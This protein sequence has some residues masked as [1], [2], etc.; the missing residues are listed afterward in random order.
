MA[1]TDAQKGQLADLY[2]QASDTGD[3]ASMSRIKAALQ[4]DREAQAP[5]PTEGMSTAQKFFAG[6]G[7]TLNRWNNTMRMMNAGD[8]VNPETGEVV[9]QSKLRAAV[10]ADIAEQKQRDKPLMATTAGSLGSVAPNA[11]LTL[12]GG[13][14]GAVAGGAVGGALDTGDVQGAAT[15]AA[16]GLAG[17]LA[18][19]VVGAGLK[20]GASKLTDVGKEAVAFLQQHGINLSM[21]QLTGRDIA[22]TADA[23][24]GQVKDLTT[25]ALKFMG[26]SSDRASAPVMDA[27]RR[28]LQN[29]YNDIAARTQ[30]KFSPEFGETLSHL[31]STANDLLEPGQAKI[32]NG[33]I[34]KIRNMAMSGPEGAPGMTIS[35]TA[36]KNLEESIGNVSGDGG[37][38][39][40]VDGIRSAMRDAMVQS[41]S[42]ADAALLARTNQQYSAMKLLE[43]SIGNKG[44]YADRIDPNKLASAVDT[45][46]NASASVYGRGANAELAQLGNYAG[47]IM[48]NEPAE[49]GVGAL[50][51]EI[52]RRLAVGGILGYGT[53]GRTGSI[54]EGGILGIGAALGGPALV[55]AMVSNPMVKN[56][57]VAFATKNGIRTAADVVARGARMGGQAT[58]GAVAAAGNQPQ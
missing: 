11:A 32:I 57:V 3:S 15:G 40:F 44:I 41:A 10:Q 19:K 31:E 25:A 55:R 21:G 6:A 5:N 49:K 17:G 29:A 48:G 33:Q 4:A 12:A 52:T 28:V 1:L 46:R 42:P 53:Y 14:P 27:G 9:D 43:K 36:F 38:Q 18:G 13:I 24:L 26:V 50:A 45:A 30:V 58:G 2:Q 7:A 34:A 56:A 20:A 23:A 39:P 35:G 51:G 8:A 37:K 54:G 16:G 47:Q 22:Q